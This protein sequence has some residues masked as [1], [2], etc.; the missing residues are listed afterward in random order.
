M[1]FLFIIGIAFA[2][3]MDAFAVSIA[4]GLALIP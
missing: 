2:L 4:V 3:A 1:S